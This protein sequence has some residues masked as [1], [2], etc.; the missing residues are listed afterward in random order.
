[1]LC[2][3]LIREESGDVLNLIW[4]VAL[5]LRPLTFSELGHILSSI[6]ENARAKQEPSHKEINSEIQP[7]T[8]KELRI[9]VQSSLGFLRATAETVSI[10]HHTATEYLLNESNKGNL[11]VPSKS[12][13]DLTLSWECFRYLH[14]AFGDPGRLPRTTVR[15]CHN[16]FQ[17]SSLQRDNQ[18]EDHGETPL[19]VAQTIPQVT[20]AKQTYLRY[21]AESWYIHARRSIEISKDK[22]CAD[23]AYNWLQ[24]QFFETS[25]VIRNPWIEL[26]GDSRMEV[27]AGEQTALHIA[28]C[29]GLTPLVE[30]A[31]SSFTK[32]K[33]GNQSPLHLAARFI[34]GAYKILI[35]KG[36][37]SLLTDPDQ[38]GNTPLHEAAI[39]GHL[40]MIKALVK[41]SQGTRHT[42][43][44]STRK[45][46]RAILHFT[47]LVNSITPR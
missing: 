22:F 38:N 1:M 33:N 29:L 5:A 39:S 25:D 47:S 23:S 14:Y 40:S 7:R 13:A 41:N 20:A 15:G 19:E 30:K 4:S 18:D 46:T 36:G 12:E 27:L 2:T 6:E 9:Y 21:A 16:G 11:P 3:L 34:S 45:T 28:V 44:K 26:C 42:I 8:E 24:H 31:L 35:S 10:V 17:N 37:P 32:G 43:M